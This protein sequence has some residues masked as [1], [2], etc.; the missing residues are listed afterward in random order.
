M[1]RRFVIIITVIILSYI[2]GCNE[3]EK[4]TGAD[5]PGEIEIEKTM[6]EPNVPPEVN[7]VPEVNVAPEPNTAGFHDF[8]AGRLVT[9]SG[10]CN[11][12]RSIFFKR[13]FRRPV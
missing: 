7:V 9:S 8:C 2:A 6:P 13:N 5:G 1:V 12:K 3:K 10:C 11:F 4:T